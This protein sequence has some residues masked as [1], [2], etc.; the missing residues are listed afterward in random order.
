MSENGDNVEATEPYSILGRALDECDGNRDMAEVLAMRNAGY[1]IKQ[2]G[3]LQAEQRRLD[4]YLAEVQHWVQV[5]IEKAQQ[6]IVR[7]TLILDAFFTDLP[8]AKG[9]TLSLPEGKISRRKNSA[10][11]EKNDDA[12][13]AFILGSMSDRA[14]EFLEPQPPKVKWPVL[15]EGVEYAGDGQAVW[16]ETGEIMAV[17]LEYDVEDPL[18]GEATTEVRETLVLR[19]VQ[20]DTSY[21]VTVTPAVEEVDEHGTD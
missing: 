9:R 5:Q 21:S 17:A 7:H 15:W 4:L 13:R 3:K 20:P 1:R 2:I 14:E 10:R 6:D 8:P 16:R 18:S 11:T 19:E 12:A